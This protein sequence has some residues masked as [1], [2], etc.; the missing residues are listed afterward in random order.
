MHYGK[1]RVKVIKTVFSNL[2]ALPAVAAPFFNIV[3]HTI[4]GSV[5]FFCQGV[6]VYNKH[7]ITYQIIYLRC[8]YLNWEFIFPSIVFQTH[9]HH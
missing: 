7:L 9:H 2:I 1:I 6:I 4:A 3:E 5:K 8:P